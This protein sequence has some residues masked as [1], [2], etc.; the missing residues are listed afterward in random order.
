MPSG[1]ITIRVEN[2]DKLT[3]HIITNF[4]QIADQKQITPTPDVQSADLATQQSSQTQNAAYQEFLRKV[5][6]R[7]DEVS[8]E[9]SVK[10]QL[11]KDNVAVFEM[12]REKNLEFIINETPLREIVGKF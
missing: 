1:F 5:A 4:N 9:L 3:A 11:S 7:I 12:R 2:P 10:S 6:L 8:K